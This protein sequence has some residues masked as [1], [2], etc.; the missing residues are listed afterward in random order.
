[1]LF[2]K[3]RKL[4]L[5]LQRYCKKGI[6]KHL[7]SKKTIFGLALKTS[8]SAPAIQYVAVVKNVREVTLFGI[9]NLAFWRERLN[10]EK[11]L[12]FDHDG[13]ADLAISAT[14]LRWM[15]VRTKEL[16]FSISVC[17][18]QAPTMLAGSYLIHAFN[19]SRLFAAMERT[20]FQTPYYMGDIQVEDRLPS[21]FRLRNTGAIVLDASMSSQIPLSQ[22]IDEMWEGTIFLPHGQTKAGPGKLFHAKLGG[23]TEVYPFSPS[24]DTLVLKPTREGIL[25]WLIESEFSAKEWRIRHAAIHAR[26]NTFKRSVES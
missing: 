26:S 19:S 6:A 20:L 16:T 1:M 22:S 8:I 5:Y 18:A 7:L 21:S 10:L 2:H 15:G 11:L 12:P 13:K 25:P 24:I 4:V 17:V 23:L 14:E 9:A 3:A